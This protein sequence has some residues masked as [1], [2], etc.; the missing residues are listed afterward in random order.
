M[1]ATGMASWFEN[2]SPSQ[3]SR[4]TASASGS[5]PSSA[6]GPAYRARN[7]ATWDRAP[8]FCAYSTAAA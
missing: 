7:S 8:I 6:S 4:S 5:R 2:R 3:T 1:R